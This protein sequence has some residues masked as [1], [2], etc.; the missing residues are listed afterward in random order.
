VSNA[1]AVAAG[2]CCHN[3]EDTH[4]HPCALTMQPVGRLLTEQAAGRDATVLK[5]CGAAC[6]SCFQLQAGLSRPQGIQCSG[7]LFRLIKNAMAINHY[8]C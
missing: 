4:T 2:P 6:W 1:A 7:F 8:Q 5:L 3:H